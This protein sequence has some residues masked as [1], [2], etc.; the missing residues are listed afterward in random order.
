[1]SRTLRRLAAVALPA[2]VMLATIAVPPASAKTLAHWATFQGEVDRGGRSGV[3]GDN[4]GTPTVENGTCTDTG[5]SVTD[6]N[7]SVGWSI[8]RSI[9][10]VRP[11]ELLEGHGSYT[12]S[13]NETVFVPLY[14]AGELGSGVL[15]G[16]MTVVRP[17]GPQVVHMV[18][19]AGDFCGALMLAGSLTSVQLA[20]PTRTGGFSGHVDLLYG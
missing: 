12:T 16:R 10:D 6:T 11:G 1:M 18:I 7:C 3:A 17:E 13:T 2:T 5:T 9:C 15:E 19:D 8:D 4:V 20:S 14:G